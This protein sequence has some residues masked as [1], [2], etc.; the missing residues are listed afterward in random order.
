[1]MKRRFLKTHLI[2]A[3]IFA[4][5]LLGCSVNGNSQVRAVNF[6]EAGKLYCV[7]SSGSRVNIADI[8]AGGECGEDFVRQGDLYDHIGSG[9]GFSVPPEEADC[10]TQV[11][12]KW[13]VN[14]PSFIFIV[15]SL[16]ENG[17]EIRTPEESVIER[18]ELRADSRCFIDF[19]VLPDVREGDVFE[20]LLS[21]QTIPITVGKINSSR[22]GGAVSG[23]EPI[24]DE[25]R[26]G[27]WS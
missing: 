25:V 27:I 7:A 3:T 1:M 22:G 14:G 10:T 12:T 23:L 6:T 8:V 15:H 24:G 9:S 4:L 11:A 5:L 21:N 17:I 20:I 18:R 19:W 13:S 26:I 16:G 2:V